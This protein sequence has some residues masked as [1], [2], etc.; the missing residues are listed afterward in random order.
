MVM[1]QTGR[2][3]CDVLLDQTILPGVGNIIKNE[4]LFFFISG[5]CNH[6]HYETVSSYDYG[7]LMGRLGGLEL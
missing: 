5:Y 4:V 6:F 1:E 2:Q 7:G 3:L